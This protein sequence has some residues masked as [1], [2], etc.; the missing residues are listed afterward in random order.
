[1]MQTTRVR[2]AGGLLA[3]ALAAPVGAQES[4]RLGGNDVAVYNLAGEVEVVAGSGSEVVVTV[5]P[6]GNDAGRLSVEVGQIR[7]RMALRVLYPSDEIVYAMDGRGRYNT[8]T[9]V[10][11]DGT[12]GNGDGGDRVRIRSSGSGLEA[13]ADLRIEVPAGVD[14]QVY[15]A[16]GLASSRNVRGDLLLDLA[17]GGV[18]VAG[19]T[20]RLEVDTGSGS[21]RVEDVEGDVEIDTGSG[22]VRLNRIAGDRVYVDTGSGSVEG[23]SIESRSLE[24]DTGS[25]R[26]ELTGVRAPDVTVDTGSGGVELEILSTVESLEVDTGS[27]GVTLA[28]PSGLDADIEVDTGSGGIDVDFPVEVRSMRR[29]YFRGRVGEGRG[30]IMVDTGSGGVR[31]RTSGG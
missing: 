7:G 2:W 5:S 28:L 30:R 22:S 31:L 24:V 25:G 10:R 19:H 6:G 27:G 11:S 29:N 1:M 17:S 13:H 23:G 9:R 14:I 18:E 3:V 20:G 16:V 4:Y 21:V 12:F 15:N 26:V 8:Q